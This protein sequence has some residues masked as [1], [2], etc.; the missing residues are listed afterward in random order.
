MWSKQSADEK[1]KHPKKMFSK[2]GRKYYK[3]IR[4]GAEPGLAI[5]A[6]ELDPQWDY[7][8]ELGTANGLALSDEELIRFANPKSTNE[9]G[10][11][12][13]LGGIKLYVF[14]D[15]DRLPTST[16]VDETN[17]SF[18]D[19]A[20]LLSVDKDGSFK[21]ITPYVETAPAIWSAPS[22]V[23]WM[24]EMVKIT[25]AYPA[26]YGQGTTTDATTGGM[27]MWWNTGEVNLG[28]TYTFSGDVDPDRPQ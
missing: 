24:K 3:P 22:S 20:E 25:K 18:S 6:V 19:Y 1:R 13:S 28:N 9:Q 4:V 7:P 17:F 5:E 23:N 14:T 10:Q 8:D 11:N 26:F 27:P 2:N 16:D 21:V 15:E 12:N